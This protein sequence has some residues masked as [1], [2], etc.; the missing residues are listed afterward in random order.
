MKQAVVEDE[1]EAIIDI[2]GKGMNFLGFAVAL[3]KL[4]QTSSQPSIFIFRYFRSTSKFGT[5]LLPTT[6]T[7]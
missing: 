4:N 6:C 7:C 5:G 2:L 3:I 1:L